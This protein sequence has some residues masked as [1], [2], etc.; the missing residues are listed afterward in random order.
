[1]INYTSIARK[2]VYCDNFAQYQKP[3]F[4]PMLIIGITGTL[5]AGKGTIVDY[6]SEKLHFI[7]FSVRGFLT[8]EIIRRGMEVNRDSMVEVANELRA[9]HSPSYIVEQLYLQAAKHGNNC[10]IESIRTPGEVEMLSSKPDFHLLA[11]DADPGIRYSRITSRNSETDRIGFEEF[12]MNEKREMESS[13]PNKQNIAWCMQH[14]DVV[15][16]NN[17]SYEELFKQ[18]E[19]YL[20]SIHI[21]NPNNTQ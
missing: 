8:D 19:K 6:L 4:H 2:G 20:E 3:S 10:I 15:F 12:L 13:D 1:M 11:V 18:L 17:G 14:A 21:I 7:H 5:G 16:V 9:A